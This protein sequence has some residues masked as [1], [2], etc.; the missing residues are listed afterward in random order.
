MTHTQRKKTQ[1]APFSAPR[2]ERYRYYGYTA[3]VNLLDYTACTLPVTTADK[4]IDVAVASFKPVSDL[5]RQVAGD[6]TSFFSLSLFFFTFF[7]SPPP[8]LS[9]FLPYRKETR[10]DFHTCVYVL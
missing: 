4:N 9:A 2:R 6:C 8:P 1:V 5:D 10:A 7:S 3:I